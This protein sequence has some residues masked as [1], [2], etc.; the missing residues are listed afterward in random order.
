[1]LAT[2]PTSLFTRS[3][4]AVSFPAHFNNVPPCILP[5]TRNC[6]RQVSTAIRILLVRILDWFSQSTPNRNVPAAVDPVVPAERAEEL[7]EPVAVAVPA[8]R[9]ERVEPVERGVAGGMAGL[10]VAAVLVHL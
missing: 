6:A 8:A 9:V 10:P 4:H 7:E 1:M 3:M 2:N 5:Q